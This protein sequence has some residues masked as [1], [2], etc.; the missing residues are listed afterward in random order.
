MIHQLK[1]VWQ[2]YV[3]PMLQRPERLQVAA[4]CYRTRKGAREV[5]LITSRGTGRWILPK[6]WP[7]KGLDA[8]GAAMQEA[9][10]EAGVKKGKTEPE[11]I[12]TYTYQKGLPGNWSIAVKTLVFPV[13]VIALASDFPEVDQRKRQ[14]FSPEEAAERVDEPE[15]KAILAAF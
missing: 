10:E 8:A 5:L 1:S 13:E 15:L 2:G 6:G 4:L 11:A 14:W 3:M 12:G 9:W 7:I